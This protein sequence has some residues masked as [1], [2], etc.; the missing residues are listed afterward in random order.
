[1]KY[2]KLPIER[3]YERM[4]EAQRAD[5]D[6]R[7]RGALMLETMST[8]GFQFVTGVLRNVEHATLAGLRAGLY[9]NRPDFAVG[10]LNVIEEIRRMLRAYLPGPE[11]EKVDWHDQEDEA[12]ALD[13]S[14]DDP[15]NG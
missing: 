11:Q 9:A 12:F 1:M 2:R 10:R 3:E 13:A 4:T 14:A 8:K 15:D 7:T 6:A 5:F